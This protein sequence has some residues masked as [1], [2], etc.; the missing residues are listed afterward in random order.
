MHGNYDDPQLPEF[1]NKVIA[2]HNCNLDIHGKK[3]T[4]TWTDLATTMN[5]G[6]DT[7]TLIKPDDV[8]SIDWEMG[9]DVVIASTSFDHYEAETFRIVEVLGNNQYR[10]NTTAQYKHYSEVETY[11]NIDFPMRAEVGLLTRN[12][13]I[14]GDEN[15]VKD[16]YGV[17]VMIMGK[18]VSRGRVEY[19]E[20][21]KCG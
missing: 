11:G 20:I 17:H 10:L 19:V 12:I 4:P 15:S 21:T 18:D 6:D 16:E 5:A 2:C 9:D 3:R 13:L 8:A 1:G 14:Q 7:I